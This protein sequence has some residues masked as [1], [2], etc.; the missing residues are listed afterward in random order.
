M[1]ARNGGGIAASAG[2]RSVA[3][4]YRE[5]A[6]SLQL[7][8]EAL[9]KLENVIRAVLT[10]P[11]D[12]LGLDDKEYRQRTAEHV[13]RSFRGLKEIVTN[14]RHITVLVLSH[15]TYGLGPGTQL[16]LDAGGRRLLAAAGGLSSRHLRLL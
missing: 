15:P 8:E 11:T 4:L 14:A 3:E 13:E 10:N 5:V 1:M 16:G 6:R 9:A 7:S 2:A 12:K